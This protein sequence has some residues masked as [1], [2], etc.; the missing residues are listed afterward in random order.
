MVSAS[1]RWLMDTMMPTLM[2]V[3]MTCVTGTF[4]MFASSLAVTNSVSFNTLLSAISW[5]SSSCWRLM[6]FSRFSLR[7]L[8]A[9]VLPL[10]VRRA[11]VS[12]TCL[13]TSSSLTSGLANDVFLF[14]SRSLPWRSLGLSPPL[15][16]RADCCSTALMSTFSLLIRLRFFFFLPSSSA[17]P[18]SLRLA[19][20]STLRISLM[21]A[22]FICFFCSWRSFSFSSR[23]FRRSSFDFFLGRVDWFS[24]SKSI[25]PM[26]L[27]F[28]TNSVGR[29]LNMLSSF[30]SSSFFSS[31]L[32][33][34][35]TSVVVSWAG[36]S[37]LGRVGV[38][39]GSVATVSFFSSA[40]GVFSSC[41]VG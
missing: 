39:C 18:F 27:I 34:S 1:R 40:T 19:L 37:S 41:F 23:S 7:Y 33:F 13:A 21:M 5:S 12:F 22:S 4:I 16:L 29:I 3:P 15:P 6:A 35:V 31:T 2:Q 25:W 32:L 10:L 11:N 36:T 24:A 30:C 20:S 38:G 28:E 14:R 8:D 26:T 17:S 9:L